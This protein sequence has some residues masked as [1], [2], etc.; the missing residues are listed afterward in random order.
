V[1]ATASA[2]KRERPS[3][4]FETIA[5]DLW[6]IFC[7]GSVADLWRS[8]AQSVAPGAPTVVRSQ[9]PSFRSASP[10]VTVVRMMRCMGFLVFFVACAVEPT[11][12]PPRQLPFGVSPTNVDLPPPAAPMSDTLAALAAAVVTASPGTELSITFEDL[13]TGEHAAIA[14]DTMHVSASSAK[15][16]WVAA[17]LDGAGLSAVEPYAQPIFANSDNYA[18]GSVIDLIGPNA[19]NTYTWNQVGMTHTALTQ[20][21]F[22]ATRIA[23]NSPRALGDDNYMTSDDAVRFLVKLAHHDI[24][25]DAR[26]TALQGWLTLS[27]NTGVGGWLVARLPADVQ[28]SVEHKAGWLPPGCCSDDRYYNTLNEIGIVTTP[29]GRSYAVSI[30]ARRGTDYWSAQ[31]PFVEFA[32]CAIYRAF[33]ADDTIACA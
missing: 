24:L 28:A 20:W 13:Q 16:W 15:A 33:T 30:L 2:R 29:D 3:Q 31:A 26:G 10:C 5:G 22:G 17:A 6:R 19:V 9:S 1:R 21:S 14:G 23:T 32:S 8:M 18:S 27:P 4:F 12:A 11:G 7:G 25:G